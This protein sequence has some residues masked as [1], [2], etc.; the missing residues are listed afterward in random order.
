[1][2]ST[3]PIVQNIELTHR[4]HLHRIRHSCVLKQVQTLDLNHTRE[5]PCACGLIMSQKARCSFSVCKHM[6]VGCFRWFWYSISSA[7]PIVN[8]RIGRTRW[9][10][11]EA[12]AWQRSRV[13]MCTSSTD[14]IIELT[15]QQSHVHLILRDAVPRCNPGWDLRQ[16]VKTDSTNKVLAV[17]RTSSS[18]CLDSFLVSD[19][20]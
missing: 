2:A 11:R 14:E 12:Y 13:N 6:V 7:K 15:V 1:M 20:N 16:A 8:R 9:V 10:W 18:S 4:K 19:I 5:H 17:Q 3:P